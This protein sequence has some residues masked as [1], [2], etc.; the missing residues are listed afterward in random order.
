MA[1]KAKKVTKK[2]VSNRRPRVTKAAKSR[3]AVASSDVR[4]YTPSISPFLDP[5]DVQKIAENPV[6]VPEHLKWLTE[7]ADAAVH[8]TFEIMEIHH[9]LDSA[10]PG[11]YEIYKGKCL[12]RTAS[13]THGERVQEVGHYIQQLEKSAIAVIDRLEKEQKLTAELDD[14]IIKQR[15]D[16]K[17]LYEALDSLD[18]EFTPWQLF[19]QAIRK[20]FTGRRFE[21]Y[22]YID[23]E[24]KTQPE[25]VRWRSS[26]KQLN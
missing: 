25:I 8:D 17:D 21:D 6:E 16:L 13:F 4:V 15:G 23:D 11:T 12:I 7:T 19:K 26:Q 9:R 10:E 22:R 1:T 24:G 2:K 14:L 18:A 20:L 3:P 5:K